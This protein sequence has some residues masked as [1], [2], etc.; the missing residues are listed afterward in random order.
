MAASSLHLLAA[1]TAAAP[2]PAR[3][4]TNVLLP[5]AVKSRV[6]TGRHGKTAQTDAQHLTDKLKKALEMLE[7]DEE[8]YYK[9]P[10][11]L[12]KLVDAV[13]DAKA[14]AANLVKTGTPAT[15]HARFSVLNES[16]EP[17][18]D[19]GILSMVTSSAPCTIAKGIEN[20]SDPLW[21]SLK[22]GL[23]ALFSGTTILAGGENL[24]ILLS[25]AK[26]GADITAAEYEPYMGFFCSPSKDGQQIRTDSVT[27]KEYKTDA[28][29]C[30]N[31]ELSWDAKPHSRLGPVADLCTAPDMSAYTEKG[32][33]GSLSSQDLVLGV[34]DYM[35][36]W[37]DDPYAINVPG[38]D[39]LLGI[40][41]FDI[42]YC[43]QCAGLC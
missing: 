21:D 13:D 6:V 33:C 16:S 10:L 11:E 17:T 27:G 8:L 40:V 22:A 14:G 28:W 25:A 3:N 37:L 30:G 9:N 24:Q 35:P 19:Q 18:N 1:M 39:C 38:M 42:Y 5:D 32:I 7:A 26:Y 4:S 31:S 2:P 15:R 23:A 29:Y 12:K 20:A 43:K 36:Q 41:D 34:C